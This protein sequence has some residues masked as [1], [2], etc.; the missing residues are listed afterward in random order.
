MTMNKTQE[1][2]DQQLL[3]KHREDHENQLQQ[4]SCFVKET[5]NGL[6]LVQIAKDRPSLGVAI[7][8]GANTRQPLPR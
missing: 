7:E 4:M 6:K 2:L 1:T 3:N 5:G 8:G